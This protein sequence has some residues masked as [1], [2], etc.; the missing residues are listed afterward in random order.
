MRH[1]IRDTKADGINT[2]CGKAFGDEAP[3]LFH[4]LDTWFCADEDKCEQTC[5]GC[6]RA[7]RRK[8][9]STR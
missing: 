4:N 1:C 7:I 5:T 9:E 2:L 8:L 3:A 6:A